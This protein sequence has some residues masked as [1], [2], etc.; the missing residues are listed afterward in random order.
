MVHTGERPYTCPFCLRKFTQRGNLKRHHE[1]HH[2]DEVVDQKE[3]SLVVEE[4]DIDA[5]K[6]AVMETA[7]YQEP[8]VTE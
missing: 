7:E 5:M 6:P 2:R 4:V 3:V 8:P 1:R